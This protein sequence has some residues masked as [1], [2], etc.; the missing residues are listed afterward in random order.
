MKSGQNQNSAAEEKGEKV[1]LAIQSY[2]N[3]Q[4][5]VRL[6]I[7]LGRCSYTAFKKN[8]KG[9]TVLLQSNVTKSL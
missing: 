5:Q 6:Y 7:Q 9:S 2:C 8:A 1:M 4:N 3:K